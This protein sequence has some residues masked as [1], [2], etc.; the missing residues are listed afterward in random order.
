MLKLPQNLTANE[1]RESRRS[2][3]TLTRFW[4]RQ[5]PAPKSMGVARTG[6]LSP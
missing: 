2:R 4:F 1:T 3:Y 5:R 6:R